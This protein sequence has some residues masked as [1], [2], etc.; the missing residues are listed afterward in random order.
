MDA[1]PLPPRPM[2]ERYQQL[3]RELLEAGN[4]GDAKELRAW[5]GRWLEG[6]ARERDG[7]LTPEVK[8]EAERAAERVALQAREQA[9]APWSLAGAQEALA[10]LHAFAGW[11][12]LVKHVQGLTLATSGVARFEAAADAIVDG[13]VTRLRALLAEDVTLIQARS[14]RRHHS[15]LLHYVAANGIEDFRQRTPANILEVTKVL[16]DAGAEVDAANGDYGGHG[17]ALGLVATSAHPR[18]AGVQI[19]LLELLVAAGAGVDGIAGGWSPVQAALANGCPEAAAWLADHGARLDIVSAAGAGRRDLVEQSL[20][21]GGVARQQMEKAFIFAC[22]CGRPAVAQL[23]L[24][25]GVDIAASDGQTALHLATHARQLETVRLLLARGA[26]LEVKN[27]YGGTVL[28]QAL[29]SA[30]HNPDV[31]YLPIVEALIAAGAQ[32]EPECSTG[33]AP[34][35]EALRRG[36]DRQGT[37]R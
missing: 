16:L 24:D 36:L 30:V 21:A 15:T 28:D 19:A 11:P 6:L 12:E 29:W 35:D 22:A 9:P 33:I 25:A 14:D 2:V 31:D 18:R 5:A 37:R 34:I 7:T 1:I 26:P 32:I 20:A 27:R 4:A 10:R 13:D 17:T 8:A 3:A 23:L